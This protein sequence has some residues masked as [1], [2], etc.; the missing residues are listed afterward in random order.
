MPSARACKGILHTKYFVVM[1]LAKLA[2]FTFKPNQFHD[3]SIMISSVFVGAT[4]MQDTFAHATH[5]AGRPSAA[6]DDRV[7]CIQGRN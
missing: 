2:F 5:S 3:Y 4:C 6:R 7:S 1:N